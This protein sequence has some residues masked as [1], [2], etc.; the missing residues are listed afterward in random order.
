MENIAGIVKEY[1]IKRNSVKYLSYIY[2]HPE[3]WFIRIPT[4]DSSIDGERTGMNPS[5]YPSF[6]RQNSKDTQSSND[7][8]SVTLKVQLKKGF[9]PT[10]QNTEKDSFLD[11]S[12]ASVSAEPSKHFGY[13]YY[14]QLCIFI[15]HSILYLRYQSCLRW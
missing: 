13:I 3:L 8:L 4:I 15:I 9:A 12:V 7:N 1:I 11:V 6:D 5:N 2:D 10:K 14:A